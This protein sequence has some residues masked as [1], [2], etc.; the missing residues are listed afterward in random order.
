[1]ASFSYLLYNSNR[2]RH[3]VMPKYSCISTDDDKY[4][5]VYHF[6]IISFC[7]VNTF[8]YCGISQIPNGNPYQVGTL[9]KDPKQCDMFFFVRS[10]HE[11][12][13][14]QQQHAWNSVLQNRTFTRTL[15]MSHVFNNGPS[16]ICGRQ[17]LK[18]LKW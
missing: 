18:H 3:L 14:Q 17:H 12:P 6:Q 8:I 4:I 2:R 1:M 16:K 10:F 5:H 9:R 15:Q 13:P 7:W 11:L